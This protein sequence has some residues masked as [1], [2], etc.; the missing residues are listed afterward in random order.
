MVV[1]VFVRVRSGA[2]AQLSGAYY[3]VKTSTRLSTTAC[4]LLALQA[5]SGALCGDQYTSQWRSVHVSVETIT[6]NSMSSTGYPISEC[7]IA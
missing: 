6:H 4:Q 7:P 2:S 3:A 5:F 1:L